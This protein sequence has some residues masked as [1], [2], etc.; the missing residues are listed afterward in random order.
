VPILSAGPR[1]S[2][3]KA[4]KQAR[5]SRQPLAPSED[6]EFG[7]DEEYEEE[8]NNNNNKKKKKKRT[9]NR[10]SS[11]PL[12]PSEDEE[13]DSDGEYEASEEETPAKNPQKQN[14]PPQKR[15]SR[16]VSN[17]QLNN[18]APG[19]GSRPLATI[20]LSTSLSAPSIQ[21]STQGD[22]D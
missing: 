17:I 22:G 8:K 15:R 14:R 13:Y 12:A 6:K 20:L 19:P 2:R 1:K 4:S 10:R 18:P 7:G 16:R 3:R 5:E 21:G 9:K 11:Q